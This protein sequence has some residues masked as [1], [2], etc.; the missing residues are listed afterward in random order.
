MKALRTLPIKRKNGYES[1]ED[2]EPNSIMADIADISLETYKKR[3]CDNTG[4]GLMQPTIPAT[5]TFELKGHILS[6]LKEIP[7]T[8]KDHEDA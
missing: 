3:I 6:T 4:S 2:D 7:L 1:D 5:G 8:R